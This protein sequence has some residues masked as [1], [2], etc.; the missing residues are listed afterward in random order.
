MLF[1]YIF[2]TKNNDV[3]LVKYL[4]FLSKMRKTHWVILSESGHALIHVLKILI[5]YKVWRRS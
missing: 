2:T 3:S 4:G 1:D 5:C